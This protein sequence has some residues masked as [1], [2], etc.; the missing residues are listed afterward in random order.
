MSSQVIKSMQKN[1]KAISIEY[2]DRTTAW[3]RPEDYPSTSAKAAFAQL[4]EEHI[5]AYKPETTRVA[6]K[7]SEHK[8]EKDMRTHY[9][10]Y[11]LNKDDRVIAVKH[12][13]MKDGNE[14]SCQEM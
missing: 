10:L 14:K 4:A 5:G 7:L 6:L 12:L 3:F 13:F 9:T 1:G 11:E 8:S 2:V